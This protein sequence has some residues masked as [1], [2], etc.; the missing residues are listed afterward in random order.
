M[1]K[2]GNLSTN[3]YDDEYTIDEE[4]LWKKE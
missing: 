4:L 1:E 3:A 2:L